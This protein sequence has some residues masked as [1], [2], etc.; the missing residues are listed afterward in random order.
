MESLVTHLRKQTL[1]TDGQEVNRASTFCDVLGSQYFRVTPPLKED[2]GMATTDENTLIEMLY[3]TQMYLFDNPEMI[4]D[5]AKCL[6]SRC[7]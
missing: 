7:L 4:D 3:E 6:L 1:L 5:I 2:I